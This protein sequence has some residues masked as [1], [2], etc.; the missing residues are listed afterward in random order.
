MYSKFI[1]PFALLSLSMT[2]FGQSK[3]GFEIGFDSTAMK[4]QL[5]SKTTFM[6]NHNREI[7][8]TSENTTISYN[9]QGYISSLLNR[10][11]NVSFSYNAHGYLINE[12]VHWVRVPVG[13]SEDTSYYTNI[14]VHEDFGSV[15]RLKE[16]GYCIRSTSDYCWGRND[17]FS[18]DTLGRISAVANWTYSS[19]TSVT[20]SNYIY[21]ESGLL[22][23][24]VS[25]DNRYIIEYF[26][27]RDGLET[28]RI[29]T[30]D[31]IL[32]RRE[33]SIYEYY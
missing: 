11:T 33:V 6:V 32:L 9:E 15:Y 19:D 28:E 24:T 22:L 29:T 7:P 13:Y 27:T 23:K 20:V 26:Y 3:Y 30:L 8:D 21:S 14:Q 17:I 25:D 5:K 1:V 4:F 16:D 18:Y 12:F 31:G 10:S 2:V